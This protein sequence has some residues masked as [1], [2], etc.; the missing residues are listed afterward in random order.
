MAAERVLIAEDN[1]K[2]MKLFRDVLQVSGY[3]TLE[4]TTGEQAV[5]LATRHAPDLV[6]MDIQL[7]G[8]DGLAAL[9]R[10]REDVRT[11]AIAGRRADGPGDGRGPRALPRGGVR[12]LHVQ[13][14]GRRGVHRHGQALLR[15]AG[16]MASNGAGRILVVDDI[17]ENVRLLEAV[18]VPRGYEVLTATSGKEAL[19]LVATAQ[20]DLILLDVVMP[21]MDGYAVCQALRDDEETAVLPVIM[22]TSSIGPRED[23]GDRGGCGRLHPEAVQPRRAPDTRSLAPAHQALPRHDQG[24]G[25][26]AAG[27]EPHARAT[28]SEPGR[29]AGAPRAAAA[30]PVT[31]ARRRDRVLGRRLGPAQPPPSGRG[32]VLR[33]PGLHGLS[34]TASSPRR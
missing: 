19:E 10:L 7:D 23:E 9:R 14:G 2:N 34:P 4:A 30:V 24:P 8:M 3:E 11:A 16:T 12:R 25:G 28:R 27:A 20:P 13:A 5:E 18:L 26:R 22:V 32:A 21:A 6:L 31:A 33:P 29:R 1:E 17:P 15:G